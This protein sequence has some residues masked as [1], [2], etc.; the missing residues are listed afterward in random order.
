MEALTRQSALFDTS[1]V[2]EEEVVTLE[3]GGGWFRLNR[4]VPKHGGK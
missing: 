3:N 2:V 4:V 1:K